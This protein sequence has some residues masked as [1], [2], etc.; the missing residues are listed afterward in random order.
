MSR[1][2]R[3][4]I[5]V[6]TLSLS[7]PLCRASLNPSREIIDLSY[8]PHLESKEI[9]KIFRQE[10]NHILSKDSKSNDLNDPKRTVLMDATAS[11]L[12]D[13]IGAVIDSLAV[14]DEGEQSSTISISFEARINAISTEGASDLFYK[15][16]SMNRQGSKVDNEE[17]ENHQAK[18]AK[19]GASDET[20][21]KAP[22]SPETAS[23]EREID[24]GINTNASDVNMEEAETAPT[25]MRHK[26]FV[27]KLD[28]GFNDI[29]QHNGD[30]NAS[31]KLHK[32]LGS[33][34]E[35]ES[36]TCPHDL[37]MDACGLG[38]PI[39]RTIGKGL[40]DR[41]THHHNR[42]RKDDEENAHH[43]S[44]QRL[45]L[46]E[47]RGIGDGGTAALAAALKL[48]RNPE[49]SLV[50]D[51]LD[52]S[53]CGVGDAGVE[54][55]SIAIESNPACVSNLDLSNNAIGDDG[56]IALANGL[57]KGCRASK[58][59]CI[60]CLDLS[61]NPDIGDDGAIALFDALEYGAIGK[62]KL[63]SC[64]IKWRGLVGLGACIGRMAANKALSSDEKPTCIEIDLSGNLLGK[65]EKK[66][67]KGLSTTVSTNMVNSMNFIGKRLKSGLKEVG[68][69]NIVGS[70]LESDDE[71]EFMDSMGSEFTEDQPT[72]SS[73]CGACEFYDALN[74]EIEAE[75]NGHF[76]SELIISLGMR[77]SNLDEN[78]IAALSAT[79][80]LVGDHTKTRFCVDCTMNGDACD[81][82]KILRALLEGNH[83]DEEVVNLAEIHID[84]LNNFRDSDYDDGDFD[85]DYD[86][87]YDD[88]II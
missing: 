74:E 54:A 19:D 41:Q 72:S 68:L 43:Q 55:L 37:R 77:M 42:N 1:Y 23:A 45:F 71:A 18:V 11:R 48:A 5:V 70:S 49:N 40:I 60:Q 57:I 16:T 12:R 62:L 24:E 85:D 36:G 87:D 46:S 67:K 38:A 51:T 52:L 65:K 22:V 9:S 31:K 34:I 86:E 35:N 84:G 29:G 73:R 53:S 33:L 88:Y 3:N 7:L 59:R 14:C 82:D 21:N 30:K 78:G 8:H 27:N 58:K 26:V 80:V 69:N 15:L 13:D 61:N 81:D 4:F 32:S 83:K 47:N 64:S 56:A 44:L 50:L 10:L 63:C 28:I 20:E 6:C 39:C 66:K 75:H 2:A 17:S 25:F 76:D 79:S